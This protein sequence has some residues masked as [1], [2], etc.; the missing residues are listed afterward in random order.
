V[1]K[2]D[3]PP[4]ANQDECIDVLRALVKEMDDR[5]LMLVTT[6]NARSTPATAGSCT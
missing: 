6:A 1:P 4:G 2:G 5:Y 3:A